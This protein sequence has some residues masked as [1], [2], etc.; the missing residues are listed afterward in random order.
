MAKKKGVPADWPRPALLARP[1][2]FRF[3]PVAA[4]VFLTGFMGV[5]K[6]AV[7]R[8]LAR[9]LGR[10]FLDTDAAVERRAG[11]SVASIFSGRG[12]PAFRRLESLEVRRACGPGKRV[13]ALGGGALL[14][15]GNLRRV[16]SS[17]ALVTLTCSEA[18]LWRR[19][20]ER[21]A[22]RPLFAG[23]RPRARLR[24]LLA[25]RRPA[26]AAA[27]FMVSTTGLSPSAAARRVARRLAR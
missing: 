5:G 13:V 21:L 1:C 17:G 18:E 2:R 11:R 3:P 8:R 26:Y 10:P 22:V 6:S 25:R 15:R 9:I 12:E 14:D 19:L 23:D 24:G 7:G 20:R 16:L 4:R 27:H